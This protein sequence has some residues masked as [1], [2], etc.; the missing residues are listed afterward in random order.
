MKN[1]VI[2]LDG[3]WNK[4]D[5]ERHEE[6]EETNV[7]N[8]WEMLNKKNSKKQIV[9]YDE[10]L[11]S[12]WYDRIRGGISGRGL[13]K[14]IREAYFEICNNYEQGD[15]V[16]IFGFSRG[17]YTARSLS[18][19]IYSCGLI[20]KD[21]L[22]DRKIQDAFD[23]Y[24]KCD[25]SERNQFKFNNTPCEIEVLGVWDTVGALGIPISFFKKATNKF[26]QFHDTRLNKEVR[27]AF[28]ALAIDEQR[29]TFRSTLWDESKKYAGQN[30]EQV[31]FSGVHSDIGGGYKKRYHSDISFK[32][33]VDKVRDKLDLDDSTYPYKGDVKK[34]IHDSYKKYYGRKERRVATASEGYTP[35]V[36]NSVLKKVKNVST[37]IPLAL[38]DIKNRKTLSP[39]KVVS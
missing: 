23:V 17:A 6:S 32:W 20:G 14:N 37:Y 25:K 21:N 2:C 8:L 15:K 9:Y 18:G 3:T 10:G 31:W 1:I 39:Y 29:E 28:H 35:C 30:I 11:G 12:H 7:R 36:H 19:M 4:P 27:N 16:F 5:E 34:K 24:K 13:A 38:V 33:M 26:F 22:T